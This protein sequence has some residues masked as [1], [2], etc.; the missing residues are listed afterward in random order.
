[1]ATTKEKKPAIR[2]LKRER[3]KIE[4]LGDILS[5]RNFGRFAEIRENAKLEVSSIPEGEFSV[6]KGTEEMVRNEVERKAVVQSID[7]M[8][9]KHRMNWIA[10]WSNVRQGIVL[11]RR[12]DYEKMFGK[13]GAH[14]N[15]GRVQ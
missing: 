13:K 1:M 4:Q 15:H 12:V 5:V 10:R 14:L 3:G 6:I 7:H 11:V 8:F 9:K 2:V